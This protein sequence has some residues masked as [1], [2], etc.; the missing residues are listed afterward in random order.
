MFGEYGLRTY[1]FYTQNGYGAEK[2]YF[3]DEQERTVTVFAGSVDGAKEKIKALLENPENF[4]KDGF[5][6]EEVTEDNKWKSDFKNT[7][8]WGD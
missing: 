5:T 6:A 2:F 7:V 1:A 4:E 8:Y 3:E